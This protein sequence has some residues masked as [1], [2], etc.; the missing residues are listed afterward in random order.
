MIK[1][2]IG[3]FFYR[4]FGFTN[5]ESKRSK[6]IKNFL[7]GKKFEEM[8]PLPYICNKSDWREGKKITKKNRKINN[9]I[10]TRKNKK[11]NQSKKIN[12]K[13]IKKLTKK[14]SKSSRV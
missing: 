9:P 6:E 11:T 1:H 7:G 14:K 5:D 2:C 4:A 13:P 8:F 3:L 12:K 10:K